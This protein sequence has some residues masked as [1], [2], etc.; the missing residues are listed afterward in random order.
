M[1][2]RKLRELIDEHGGHMERKGELHRLYSESLDMIDRLRR[3]KEEAAAA[4]Y[5]EAAKEARGGCL[6]IPYEERNRPRPLM[7]CC[8][9]CRTAN[10][11]MD[12]AEEVRGEM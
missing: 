8:F 6:C 9:R 7:S 1:M 10:K 11:L 12:K 5:E 4:A 3:E 2:R